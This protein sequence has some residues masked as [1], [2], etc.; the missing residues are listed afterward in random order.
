MRA[1][2]EEIIDV[3]LRYQQQMARVEVLPRKE[4]EVIGVLVNDRCGESVRNDLAE[5]AVVIADR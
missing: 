1:H 3:M 4:R 5:Y 2:I